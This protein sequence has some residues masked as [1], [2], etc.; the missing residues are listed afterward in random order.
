MDL[1]LKLLKL[2]YQN[3][4]KVEND[5]VLSYNK[6]RSLIEAQKV[7]CMQ[8]DIKAFIILCQELD[9]VGKGRRREFTIPY[10]EAKQIIEK[11]DI[12]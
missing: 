7:D 12:V 3:G 5:P 11:Q 2:Y 1:N 10:L 9:I 4:K 6:F 8:K